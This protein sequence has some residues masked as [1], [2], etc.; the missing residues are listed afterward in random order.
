MGI[1]TAPRCT[2]VAPGDEKGLRPKQEGA[3]SGAYAIGGQGH[4]NPETGKEGYE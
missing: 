1:R 2:S 4:A 3:L